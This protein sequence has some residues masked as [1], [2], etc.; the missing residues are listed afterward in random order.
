MLLPIS[1]T[2]RG[3]SIFVNDEQS[4]KHPSLSD[5]IDCGM[6]TSMRDENPL[7]MFLSIFEIVGSILTNLMIS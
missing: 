5:V 1:V 2:F 6:V 3:I 4:E 7:K